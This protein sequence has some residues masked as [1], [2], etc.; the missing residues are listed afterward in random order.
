MLDRI[1]RVC[2][3][4]GRFSRMR[5][6]FTMKNPIDY[7]SRARAAFIAA[8]LLTAPCATH[9]ASAECVPVGSWAAPAASGPQPVANTDLLVRLARQSVV[10]L[11]ESHD[12]AED[13]RWQLQTLIELHAWRSHLVLAFEMFPRRVQ[14]ALDRW[15]AGEYT[16][17]EFLQAVDWNKVWNFDPQLYLPI[18]N[19]ARM[20][21]IPM[22]AI[23]VEQT[24]VRA[25]GAKGLAAVPADTRE[26]IT[27]PAAPSAA[28][29]DYLAPI[30]R[31]HQRETPAQT[32]KAFDH[33]DAAFRRFVDSQ[34]FW[35]RA[36]AQGIAG[37]VSRQGAPLV[38]GILGMGHMVQGYGV[39]HQLADLG[40]RNVS[41]LLPWQHGSE[42]KRLI[43]G[44]AEAVFGVAAAK[45]DAAP[46]RPRL[47]VQI[48]T[49]GGGV[50][51][52]AVTK[53]SIAEAAGIRDG[54]VLTEAAGVPL[55]EFMDLRAVVQRQAAGTWLPLKVMRQNETLE[56]IAKF[57][58]ARP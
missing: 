57:P 5:N 34:Q 17:A 53:G 12:S 26:G 27:N 11:G 48:D 43:A 38:V 45:V 15:V 9:A 54:D 37:A 18:F 13:H 36:M 51:V 58:P 32:E 20:N 56:L 23:N 55:K 33:N 31:E 4:C 50:R 52:L 21:R 35:D 2:T 24:L 7:R 46:E 8:A 28:Y 41:S 39:P 14:P 44:Y 40:V 49:K 19:F 30:Y 10:L 22:V 1:L 16:E 3:L 25:V 29:I 42:C 6:R 47:G